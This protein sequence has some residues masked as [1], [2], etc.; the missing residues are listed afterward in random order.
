[1][2][3]NAPKLGGLKKLGDAT[4]EDIPIEPIPTNE[5]SSSIDAPPI[6]TVNSSDAEQPSVRQQTLDESA[7]QVMDDAHHGEHVVQAEIH[8]LDQTF[9]DFSAPSLADLSSAEP[10][11]S[12]TAVSPNTPS[13]VTI[14][15]P[16]EK[17]SKLKLGKSSQ[18]TQAPP[19]P[20]VTTEPVNPCL[21]CG[22]SREPGAVFCVEC[23]Y[24]EKTG[25]KIAP[26]RGPSPLSMMENKS[27]NN[28]SPRPTR[29]APNYQLLTVYR[30]IFSGLACAGAVYYLQTEL[31]TKLFGFSE[32]ELN[33]TLTEP[34]FVIAKNYYQLSLIAAG[35][36]A[37]WAGSLI[38]NLF[39]KSPYRSYFGALFISLIVISI[40][41]VATMF[42]TIKKQDRALVKYCE[43]YLEKSFGPEIQQKWINGPAPKET[44]ELDCP[45]DYKGTVIYSGIDGKE[46]TKTAWQIE[47]S[48]HELLIDS[49]L[50]LTKKQKK[51][52]FQQQ[53]MN[54]YNNLDFWRKK[55]YDKIA[56][57]S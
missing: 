24:N 8:D 17:K 6:L 29:K 20:T 56:E 35:G 18:N 9:D 30:F 47:C 11:S 42:Q 19:P 39:M 3:E 45:C 48:A 28:S 14:E 50:E 46:P 51:K 34:Q 10:S 26:E 4:T 32:S 49:S 37:A 1:M 21:A 13:N 33:G 12:M 7:H 40:A 57:K 53:A 22:V 15:P 43:S 31:W 44:V 54:V 25:E 2:N 23:G 5:T 55:V 41:T 36:A 27:V 16:K 52:K 38:S